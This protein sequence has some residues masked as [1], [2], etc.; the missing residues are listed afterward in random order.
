MNV[1]VVGPGA[2]GGHIA[3]QFA[4]AGHNV[5]ITFSQTPERLKQ[6]A[7]AITGVTAAPLA[8]AVKMSEVIVLATRWIDI[9]EFIQG[10]GDLTGKIIFDVTNQF[11]L[12]GLEEVAGSVAE[13]NQNRMPSAKLVRTCN[14]FYASFLQEVSEGKHN[15]TTMFFTTQDPEAK[16]VAMQ[17]LPDLGFVPVY[18]DW[19][20]ADLLDMPDGLLVGKA[21]TQSTAQK[22]AAAAQNS[23]MLV[24]KE[25]AA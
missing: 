24:A 10:A 4:Q 20:H 7:A 21:I 1:T 12:S 13:F 23:D 3:K 25:L 6:K 9:H 8:Q 16:N 22:I 18:L 14:M 19:D 11:G 15:Q 5:V 17:L 2:I